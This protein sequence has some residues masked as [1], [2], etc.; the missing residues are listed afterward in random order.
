ML[1]DFS[2]A[3]EAE[4]SSTG[5]ELPWRI[6]IADDEDEV[7]A[8]TTVA[9]AGVVFKGRHIEF[10][11]AHSA[12]EARRVLEA[13]P[14]VAIILLDVVM[15]ADDAGLRLVR[16]IREQLGNKRLRIVLRTGQPGQAP[17]REVIIDHDINDYKSKTEL[18]R[19][20]LLTCIIA[21]L[22]S[23]DDILALEKSLQGLEHIVSAAG[24][25]LQAFSERTFADEILAQIGLLIGTPTDG[26][27]GRR[28]KGS[29]AISVVSAIGKYLQPDAAALSL[30]Q[31]AFDAKS[32]IYGEGEMCL[33]IQP[34]KGS[35]EYAALI[36]APRPLS[37]LERRL[38]EVLCT[39]IAAGLANVQLYESL[40]DLSRDLE[41]QVIERTRDLSIAKDAAEAANQAKSEFLAVMSHE[42]RT[43]MNGILGMMQLALQDSAN[44]DQREHLE[45]AQYSAEALLTI[46]NDILDFSKLEAGNLEFEAIAFDVIKTVESV[47]NLMS[48]R[49]HD[50]GLW[51][52]FECAPGVPR[53][54]VGDVGRLRQVLLNLISNAMK[55]TA[56]GGIVVEIAQ[57]AAA[58]G[59]VV[60][61]FAVD[62]TGIGIA[63]GATERLFQSFAQADSSIS[64][65]FGGTGL[66][67]SI[68]RKIVEMQGGTIGV[69]STLGV[70][71]RFWFE[72]P[73]VAAADGEQ[74]LPL[75]HVAQEAA[76]Y[77]MHILLAEDNEIN[78]KVAAT[79]LRKAGHT[80]QIVQNGL[81]AVEALRNGTQGSHGPYDVV[82]M[83]MHMPDMD[84]LEATRVIR[85]MD[86]PASKLPI[87][88]LTAAGALSDIQI[89]LDAGMNFFLA[90]PFRMERLHGILQEL[91]AAK[92]RAD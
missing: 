18:T 79:L 25:L 70:G 88:A 51:L 28:V 14:D 45:T 60:L 85:A 90:K 58:D 30:M 81:E 77:G 6:L 67:L 29:D 76:P 9:L 2:F 84:G 91:I 92:N 66:G 32:N 80:V 16:E 31:H 47:I 1:E 54:L 26:L 10:L 53:L 46:L 71:S 12:L 82:L 59:K 3:P 57:S 17:E 64:R 35:G 61:R 37:A 68:C 34:L 13:N 75:L 27:I 20:K 21:A 5:A 41:S 78:Q 87:V 89:C 15:E 44:L 24:S 43:P 19:Q 42:I 8:V 65:R 33:Y 74:R 36:P 55:F 40:I 86:G 49:A 83:D 72:L 38:V 56:K 73:F 23:F 69:D 62:D 4:K 63:A 7:H 11:H 52:K 48:S 39:N 22:R 50:S